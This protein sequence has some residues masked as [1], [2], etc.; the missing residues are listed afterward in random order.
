MGFFGPVMMSENKQV[1]L[2]FGPQFHIYSRDFLFLLFC[3]GKEI[4]QPKK[5]VN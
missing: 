5:I 4:L 3:V 1:N 2:E